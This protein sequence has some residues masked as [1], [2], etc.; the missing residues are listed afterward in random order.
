[1]NTRVIDMA[2]KT[3]GSIT[4]IEIAGRATSG[5]LKWLFKCECGNQ[6]EANGYYAR[7]GKI[8]TCPS[9]AAARS[10]AASIKHGLTDTPE[11]S[12]WTE[13]QTRCLNPNSTGYE[14]YGGRGI[15]VC[16]RWL[17]SFEAFLADMGRRP[18][19]QYSIERDDVNGDY[20]PGNCRWATR[21]EQARNKRNNVF[22]TING[23]AKTLSD[24]A[25]YYGV[26]R[27]T[28][29]LRHKKGLRG[30]AIFTT[31]AQ[32]ITHD[33]ITDTFSG[34]SRRTG[35]KANTIG[36]RVNKYKWSVERA[37]TQG[38]FN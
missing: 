14:N 21:A 16:P 34:W 35:I 29:S 7:T 25:D 30:A 38:A 9:C 23:I 27:G 8:N 37:L 26:S 19:I 10:R 15:A 6:F 20:E 32:Q 4:G 3:F 17:S 18:G 1:M 28:A 2:G 31:T 33:G 5:D 24:W 36:M 22:I 13:I 12:T 11:F